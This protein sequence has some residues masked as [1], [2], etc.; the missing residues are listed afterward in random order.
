MKPNA[1]PAT[2]CPPGRAAPCHNQ[3]S[4]VIHNGIGAINSAVNPDGTTFSAQATPPFPTNNINAPT[5]VAER[6]C[7]RLGRDTPRQRNQAYSSKPAVLCRIPAIRK[8]G[9][10]STLI[11]MP[12]YVEPQMTYT[13]AKAAT[14]FQNIARRYH[15]HRSEETTPK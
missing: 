9:I 7:T 10:V 5:T 6:Q 8:G 11:R 13:M 14:S 15:N 2:I 3:S 1:S 4:S 12:R